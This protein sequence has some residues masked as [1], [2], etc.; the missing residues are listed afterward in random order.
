MTLP[1]NVR[2]KAGPGALR[3][4]LRAHSRHKLTKEFYATKFR[5]ESTPH[6]LNLAP[7]HPKRA[8]E[9]LALVGHRLLTSGNLK[10]KPPSFAAVRLAHLPARSTFLYAYEHLTSLV[11]LLPCVLWPPV[12]CVCCLTERRHPG[13]RQASGRSRSLLYLLHT[14]ALCRLHRALTLV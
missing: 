3:T 2:C 10:C 13:G 1:R 4:P 5:I 9:R 7:K 8:R 11:T 14:Q 6:W 12:L